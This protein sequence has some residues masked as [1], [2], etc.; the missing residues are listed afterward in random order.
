MRKKATKN[1]TRTRRALLPVLLLCCAILTF[2]A[3]GALAQETGAPDSGFVHIAL[4][5]G[6]EV[7][8]ENR[9]GGVEVEVWGE[10]YLALATESET[11]QP[12]PS[13][14][15]PAKSK[16]A[17]PKIAPRRQQSPARV[18]RSESRLL[19]S[20]PRANVQG[21]PRVELR[22]RVPTSA[23][24]KISTSEGNVRV[25]GVPSALSAQSISG[26]I[27]VSLPTRADADITAQ[28]LNGTVTL[29]EGLDAPAGV[30]GR[31]LRQKFHASLGDGSRVV[32]LF[33][34]RGRILL[35]TLVAAAPTRDDT[36][37]AR[38]DSARLPRRTSGEEP[39]AGAPTLSR[40]ASSATRPAPQASETP[41]EV[42]DDEVVRVESDLVTLNVSVVERSSGRGLKGLAREDFRLEEDG[43]EQQV[44]HFESANA[45]FDLLLL[46]DLSG[47]TAN[48]TDIIRAA[49]RRFVAATRAQDRVAV[50]AFSGT[51]A[52]VSPLTIDRQALDSESARCCGHKATRALRCHGLRDEFLS[53][54]PRGTTPRR[55]PLKR[56]LD[57]LCRT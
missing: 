21:A 3:R 48:V 31:V 34:G 52:I 24:L 33:S 11:A 32:K 54:R 46:I 38:D 9:R 29:G 55:H 8:I 23:R 39:E 16:R 35:G 57:S 19:I 15:R 47:S 6:G 44:A 45:P 43:V 22:V 56:G 51:T 26:D 36:T 20:V 13:P 41:Q 25:S 5:P 4:P 40:P 27:D 42:D 50:V 30:T 53:A 1:F 14:S 49:A 17:R 18:E 2:A 12:A 10:D 37:P 7:E 28:S